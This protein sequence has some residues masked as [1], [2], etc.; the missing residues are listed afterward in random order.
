MDSQNDAAPTTSQPQD[1]EVVRLAETSERKNDWQLWGT[2]LPER[3]WG[4]VR[5]D[6]S[7]DGQVWGSFSYDAAQYRAYRWGEDGLLGWTDRLCRL[8]FSTS[9]WNGNDPVLKERLFGL[10]GDQGN[11]GEDVKELYYYLDATPTASYARALYKY[12]QRAFPYKGL[13]EEN[14][15]RGYADSEYELLD[16]DAFSENRYFDVQV[17]YG[18]RDPHDTLIRLTVSNRGPASA[19]LTLLPTLTFRNTWSWGHPEE[20][21]ETDG[22]NETKPMMSARAK[23]DGIVLA[24]HGDLGTYRFSLVSGAQQS[25]DAYRETL[26]TENET[27]GQ[28]L[29][30]ASQAPAIYSKDAFDRYLLHG[31]R[32]AVNPALRGTKAAFHL[33]FDLQ[34]GESRVFRLRLERAQTSEP[35]VLESTEFDAI[36]LDR[37]AEADRFYAARIP[38]S[39]NEDERNVARQA[40][41]GLIWTKQFYHYVLEEWLAGDPA[42]PPPPAQRQEGRNHDWPHVF[43]RDVLSMPDKWEYPWFAA[44]DSAFHMIP[45]AIIDPH[46]AKA[47]LLLLL[48]E[49]YM[50]PNGQ[51]PAYEFAFSDVNPPVHAWSVYHVYR[52]TARSSGHKDTDFL[53]RAFQK[54]LLNFNWWVNQNDENGHN[55]FGGGFLG[56]DNIGVF[57]R[58][59]PMPDGVKLQQADGTAWMA[60]YCSTMLQIAVELATTRPTYE[61]LA[62]KFLEHYIAIIDAINNFDDKGLW[63]EQEG[64]FFDQLHVKGRE[65][66]VLRVRSIV[67]LI[68]ICGIEIMPK[69]DLDKLPAFRRRIDWFVKHKPHLARYISAAENPDP[70]Q[71][72]AQF[73]ELVPKDRLLRILA[74]VLDETEFLSDFGIRS[75]SRYYLDHPFTIE[76]SGKELEVRYTPAEGD[77]GLFG[78]N[79]NWRGPIW[80]PINFL[81][82]NALERYHQVYG[83]S[84][85]VECPTGSGRHMTMLQVAQELERRLCSIVLRDRQGSR[86]CHGTEERYRS[87]PAWKDLVLFY[88]YFCGDTGRGCGASHQTGWTALVLTC[89]AKLHEDDLGLL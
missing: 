49:W 20:D 28:R 66:K 11:H 50:H 70:A 72:G 6:Y 83:P 16:T 69:Q 53:E 55:L 40:F 56:L 42:L 43:A 19:R 31:E 39:L 30:G 57:D 52:I 22:S 79:S 5:E 29:L 14:A 27:N 54:L 45:F 62:G 35:S 37:Q 24:D 41:A 61:D 34:P 36:F 4:T 67:G 18:K 60:F 8:C 26:F 25:P 71:A 33:C 73:I 65:S 44:W 88:E 63:D 78:G 32:A 85:T 74:K 87:D 38:A 68:P 51:I 21:E 64:F 89:F 13:I 75:L 7:A 86:P 77:S 80:F 84:L 76:L 59:M 81:L 23:A 47:Q 48:R 2:Y 46:F 3:Q 10:S 17:E 1:P 9:L 82:I 15:R 58:S 12:P